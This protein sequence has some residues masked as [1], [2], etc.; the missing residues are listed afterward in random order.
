M[1]RAFL[2]QLVSPLPCARPQQLVDGEHRAV[3]D[4]GILDLRQVPEEVARCSVAGVAVRDKT[5]LLERFPAIQ[6][7]R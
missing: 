6:P 3:V 2:Q 1:S 7:R 5:A 4:V